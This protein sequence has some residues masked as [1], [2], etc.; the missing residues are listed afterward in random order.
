MA[1]WNDISTELKRLE[2]KRD[3]EPAPLDK[4]RSKYIS[5]LS[6]LRNR[7][8]ICYYSGWLQFDQSIPQ[9]AI[10]DDDMNG[11]MNAV[12]GLDR[13]KGLDLVLHTPGGDLAATEAIVNY[14]LSCF[15]NDVVAIVPQ[16]AMSAGTMIACSCKEVIMGRQ[17]SLGPT[18]PQLGGFAAGGVIEEFNR[19]VEDAQTRP[20]SVPMWAQIIGKYHPTFLGDCQKAVEASRSIVGN[21][22]RSNML[23]EDEDRDHR[24]E[25]IVNKLCEHQS[26][27]MHNRHFSYADLIDLGMHIRILE[28]DDALQDAVLSVHHAF[29][30]TFQRLPA[31]KIIESSAD[32][33]WIIRINTN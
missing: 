9:H 17:S 6:K 28:E 3:E 30:T 31:A 11:L 16:L 33:H 29:M 22:L 13:S 23:A 26:S 10:T 14:L 24:A 15:N 7:N 20:E 21:W 5:Q 18:D 19:A 25:Q 1:S 32:R 27:G 12:H 4:I 8:V 2:E